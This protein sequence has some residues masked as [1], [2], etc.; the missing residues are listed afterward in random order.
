MTTSRLALA[1]LVCH[2][3]F[4][5]GRA[6]HPTAVIADSATLGPG[7][8][9]A[10]NAVINP[11]AQ[12]GSNVLINTAAVVDHDCILGDGVHLA[13]KSVLGGGVSVGA[14]LRG[15]GDWRGGG[16]HVAI[17]AR[18]HGRCRCRGGGRYSRPC[19]DLRGSR[20]NYPFPGPFS[21]EHRTNHM[22]ASTIASTAPSQRVLS[23]PRR[24]RARAW[25]LAL[26]LYALILIAFFSRPLF[27]HEAVSAADLLYTFDNYAYL[28]APK[29]FRPFQFPAGRPGH[30]I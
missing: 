16:D 6:I 25:V 14:C 30:A 8:V 29:D 21:K 22:T 17:G 7:A 12:L 2:Q 3:G 13:P 4:A 26:A 24:W 28:S 20:A 11:G 18:L 23:T 27:R 9:V 1:E 10:A 5:L 15:I 19:N